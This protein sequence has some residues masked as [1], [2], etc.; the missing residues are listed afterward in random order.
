MQDASSAALLAALRL[1]CALALSNFKWLQ[2]QS[3]ECGWAGLWK[4]IVQADTCT[5]LQVAGVS[6][7]PDGWVELQEC[8]CPFT[9][10]WT[11]SMAIAAAVVL[12]VMIV[13]I[14]GRQLCSLMHVYVFHYLTWTA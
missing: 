13:T 12:I 11:V 10:P 6:R 5:L 7:S 1:A 4:R 8:G 2:Q 3:G 14:D 9:A